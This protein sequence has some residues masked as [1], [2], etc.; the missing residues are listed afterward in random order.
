V[1]WFYPAIDL[2]WKELLKELFEKVAFS[3]FWLDMNEATNHCSGACY[4]KE[5][6]AT[7]VKERLPYVPTGRDLEAGSIT[8]DAYNYDGSIQL[9][10]HSLYATM[11]SKSTYEYF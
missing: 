10:T 1:D 8:L 7:P 4:D 3:G 9:D 5:I 11:M 6:S 2:V